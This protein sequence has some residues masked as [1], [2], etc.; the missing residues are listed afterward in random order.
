[1]MYRCFAADNDGVQL[2]KDTHTEAIASY[3]SYLAELDY[4]DA[5]T[6][7]LKVMKGST[8]GRYIKNNKSGLERFFS[9]ETNY[10]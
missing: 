8:I 10:A 4:V 7:D 9:H 5:K 3:E 2:A 6:K 1:M